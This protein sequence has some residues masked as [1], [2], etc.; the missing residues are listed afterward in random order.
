MATNK[1]ELIVEELWGHKHP[2]VPARLKN[3]VV[4]KRRGKKKRAP[5]VLERVIWSVHRQKGKTMRKKRRKKKEN[6]SMAEKNL[7]IHRCT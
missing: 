7:T 1:R 5:F 6:P 4:E 3:S 2:R